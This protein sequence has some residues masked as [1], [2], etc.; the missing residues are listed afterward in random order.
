MRKRLLSILFLIFLDI[1]LLH[2]DQPDPTT[3]TSYVQE[4]TLQFQYGAPAIL[5]QY[6][7]AAGIQDYHFTAQLGTL[8]ITTDGNSLKDPSLYAISFD[9]NIA[10]T[11]YVYENGQYIL[12]DTP[13]Q[14]WAITVVGGTVESTV[15]L[16]TGITN[17]A[18]NSGNLL[19]NQS[20]MTAYI[21]L[22]N[23]NKGLGYF[24]PGM[25]YTLSEDNGLGSFGVALREQGDNIAEPV[26][27]L[28]NGEET[29][30]TPIVEV[31]GDPTPDIP[32]EG[33]GYP[34]THEFDFTILNNVDSFELYNAIEGRKAPIATAQLQV[35]NG[36]PDLEYGVQI[37]FTS[38][39]PGSDFE[40]HLNGDPSQYA[41]PYYLYLNGEYLQKNI[42]TLWDDIFVPTGTITMVQRP[43]TVAVKEGTELSGAPEGSYSDTVT[44]VI[45]PLDTL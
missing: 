7:A 21:I 34:Y 42:F 40:M 39:A 4:A 5:E 9:T 20:T 14:V 22:T 6:A 27:I 10:I 25:V 38:T 37:A 16:Q 2:A 29:T 11:G 26:P 45:I 32:F 43:I 13:V 28:V 30:T 12:A 36:L 17:L 24:I 35:I 19:P 18:P 3:T 8:T 41:L 23:I 44:V 33:D 31:G 1:Q 15:Q